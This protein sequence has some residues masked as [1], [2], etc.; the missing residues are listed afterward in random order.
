MVRGHGL[1]LQVLEVETFEGAL[2]L[3]PKASIRGDAL[4]QLRRG[5]S[6]YFELFVAG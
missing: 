6:R 1:K 5:T 3:V 4:S 2:D